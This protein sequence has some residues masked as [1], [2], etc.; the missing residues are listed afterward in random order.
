MGSACS[1]TTVSN[2]PSDTM[3][4]FDPSPMKGKNLNKYL[5]HGKLADSKVKTS[6]LNLSKYEDVSAIIVILRFNHP[7]DGA[8]YGNLT[9]RLAIFCHNHNIE[10][11]PNHLYHLF[12]C[13]MKDDGYAHMFK[14]MAKL[15]EEQKSLCLNPFKLGMHCGNL[16]SG[17]LGKT[18]FDAIQLAKSCTEANINISD[19]VARNM[20]LNVYQP[21][22]HAKP[23]IKYF[24]IL[25]TSLVEKD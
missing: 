14:Q 12:A 23:T 16:R 18:V 6:C 2:K 8:Y 17:F 22:I 9:K 5:S 25:R 19:D 4:L 20:D 24:S 1:H 21:T 10:Y 7:Q 13:E 15:I 11:Y 3:D